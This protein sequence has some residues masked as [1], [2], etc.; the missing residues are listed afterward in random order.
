[1]F[2]INVL[3]QYLTTSIIIAIIWMIIARKEYKYNKKFPEF[4][5]I[6]LFPLIGWALGLSLMMIIYDYIEIKFAITMFLYQLLTFIIVY[7]ILLLT[8]ETIGYHVFHVH[9]EHGAKYG[10]IPLLDVIH[11]IWWMKIAYF[12]LGPIMFLACKFLTI[13][14]IFLV[15]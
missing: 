6:S 4:F 11:A 13:H 2:Q 7:W 9:N 3:F 8:A 15:A 5:G 12:A 10:G 1:M 14:N